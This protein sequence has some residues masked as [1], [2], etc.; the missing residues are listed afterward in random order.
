MSNKLKYLVVLSFALTVGTTVITKASGGAKMIG[1]LDFD[2]LDIND[3]GK[4]SRDEIRKQRQMVVKS[5]DLN[6]D[7]KLSAEELMQQHIRRSQ[8]SVKRMIRKLDSNGDGSL[9]FLELKKSRPA[10]NLSKMFDR[11]DED[12]DG[13]ISKD[14]V[15][16]I[17]KNL[18]IE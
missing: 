7:K 18:A 9:S 4:V 12:T 14:E 3:D 8:F 13:Y 5:M 17:K 2:D 6:G 10:K 15:Q 16:R 1:M 11:V